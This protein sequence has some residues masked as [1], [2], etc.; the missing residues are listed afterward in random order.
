[1]QLAEY[2]IPAEVAELKG[3]EVSTVYRAI[4]D[5]RIPHER[6][7]NRIVIRRT[8]AK[9]WQPSTHGGKRPGQGRPRKQVAEEEE[10]P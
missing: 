2:L 6:V 3:V 4:T 9:A 8:D 7:W 1:M 5:G 10:K